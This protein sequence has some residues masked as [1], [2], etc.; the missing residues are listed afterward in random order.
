MTSAVYTG[1]WI[2]CRRKYL[3][4]HGNPSS[5]SPLKTGLP[6][7][8]CI[9]LW[10]QEN[11]TTS[12]FFSLPVE[13]HF[14]CFSI[15]I[16][17]FIS[18]TFVSEEWINEVKWAEWVVWRMVWNLLERLFNS[19][20]RQQRKLW[21]LSCIFIEMVSAAFRSVHDYSANVHVGKLVIFFLPGSYAAIRYAEALLAPGRLLQNTGDR[22][23]NPFS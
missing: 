16:E 20:L 5:N 1:W 2:V 22:F 15:H 23:I 18:A 12:F 17:L 11:T 7:F 21:K 13:A 6:T 9:C 4:C 19:C 14:M 3:L 10:D 8:L